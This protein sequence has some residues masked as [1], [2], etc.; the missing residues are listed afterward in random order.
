MTPWEGTQVG[1]VAALVSGG[2]PSRN[3]SR[4]WGGQIP[5]ITCKD[6]KADRLGDSSER[7]T[8]AGL[9]AGSRLVPAGAVLI[10]IRGMILARDVP[11]ALATRPVSFNQDLKALLPKPGVDG[12]FLL[13]VLKSTARDLQQM[14]ARAAHGT[15]SLLT[16]NIADLE[17]PLPSL[18]EQRQ[19][20]AVLS[21][22]QRA[23][24]RQERLLALTA[25]LKKAL[26]HTLFT[27]G[28]RGEPLKQT[29]IGQVPESWDGVA[30][31]AELKVCD[32]YTP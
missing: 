1:K 20:A 6:M 31:G 28:T 32:G 23:V 22:V 12:E 25:E 14:T 30:V 8:E 2:T 17:I 27:E 19:I 10:V 9:E 26:M 18:D 16:S 21:A 5:W 11:V 4:Y 29:E 7:L 15:K 3:D 24:E 13:Y